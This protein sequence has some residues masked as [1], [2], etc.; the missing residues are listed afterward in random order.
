MNPAKQTEYK[1]IKEKG[2]SFKLPTTRGVAFNYKNKENICPNQNIEQSQASKT[3]QRI[4]ESEN[5]CPNQNIEQNQLEKSLQRITEIDES[6]ICPNQYIE[7]IAQ[8]K[9]P[10]PR[11][12]D[13]DES[14]QPCDEDVNNKSVCVTSHRFS[15]IYKPSKFLEPDQHIQNSE[16][17][18]TGRVNSNHTRHRS[19]VNHITYPEYDGRICIYTEGSKD[20]HIWMFTEGFDNIMKEQEYHELQNMLV[21]TTWEE[22]KRWSFQREYKQEKTYLEVYYSLIIYA[23]IL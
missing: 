13:I 12:A 23:N 8:V 7:Q 3:L 6:Y 9:K 15:D 1:I 16:T 21:K 10:S 5:I 20:E 17:T 11:I 2:E 22:E 14:L 19:M 4:V 18:Q